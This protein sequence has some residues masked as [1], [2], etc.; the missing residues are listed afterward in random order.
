M[1]SPAAACQRARPKILIVDDLPGKLKLIA[2]ILGDGYDTLFAT[3]GVDA[4]ALAAEQ[5]PDLILLDV[6]MPDIDGYRICA[7]QR[8]TTF[9]VDDRHPTS[10]IPSG[11]VP[12]YP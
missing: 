7:A 3:S 11:S 12:D 2:R 10:P 5:V 4:L 8:C 6:L 9:A 1:L